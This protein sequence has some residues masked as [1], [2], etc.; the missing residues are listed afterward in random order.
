VVDLRTIRK[1]FERPKEIPPEIAKEVPVLE[2]EERPI[3]PDLEVE[4]IFVKSVELKDVV[5]VQEAAEEVRKGNII[6][7]DIEELLRRDPG[8]L[9]RAVEQLKDI[10]RRLG[11]D[12]GK[13]TDS[14][15]LMTPRFIKIQF[16]RAA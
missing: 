10:S 14:K 8:E 12:I 7:V 16:R 3:A 4:P 6:V 9:R 15:I 11:G 2:V 13:L 1:L 5:E